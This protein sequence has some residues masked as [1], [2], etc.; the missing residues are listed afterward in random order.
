MQQVS[1]EVPLTKS[2]PADA[3]LTS[4]EAARRL[5]EYGLNEAVGGRRTNAIVQILIFLVNP[6]VIILLIA[7]VVSAFLGEIFNATIIAGMVLLSVALNFVQTYR[8]Q[9]AAD[10]LRSQVALTATAL[11][12]GKWVEVRRREIV[13]GDIIHLC[14]GDLVPADARLIQAKDLHINEAALTGESLPVEKEAARTPR[15]PLRP[16]H[17]TFC[18]WVLR[19]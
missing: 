6:L 12:D 9:R 17:L 3:G 19:W 1:N 18:I 10:R 15:L 14:A 8:S 16:G 7:S 11:R 5:G 13:P 4:S 2:L